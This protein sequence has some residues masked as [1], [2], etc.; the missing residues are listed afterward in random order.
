MV[1]P[2]TGAPLGSFLDLFE[3]QGSA[4]Y[5]RFVSFL[6]PDEAPG[7]RAPQF[8]WPY[9]E[10]LRMD[11]AY[12]ELAMMVTG[13]Y[14]KPLPT[15]HGAPLRVITPWKYGYKNIKAFVSI[16]FVEE[17]PHTFWNDLGPTEY[18][19][20]SNID[21]E[22]PHPRWSQA[23]ERDIGNDGERIPTL[24]YNGYESYVAELY[25]S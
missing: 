6:K 12:N 18:S 20:L 21:P 23:T 25:S 4:R 19:F 1:V 22:V 5:V 11:E 16:Q 9:Y 10:G 24:K 3:P 7:Q 15:Q 13:I 2:W 14:G 8:P 17:Q